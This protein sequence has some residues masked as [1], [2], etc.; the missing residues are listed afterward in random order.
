MVKMVQECAEGLRDAEEALRTAKDAFRLQLEE[1]A[2]LDNEAT[3][4]YDLASAAVQAGDEDT[5]RRHLTERKKVQARLADAKASASLAKER[6]ERV[7]LSVETLASQAKRLEGIL[8]SN[9]ADAAELSAREAA[10][11][12]AGAD[13]ASVAD[14]EF[15]DPLEK[16]FRELEGRG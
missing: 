13:A 7:E 2:A 10:A 12:F 15:E 6:V 11:K 16:K 14:L 3:E 5:A 9:M 8:K 4:L 1:A